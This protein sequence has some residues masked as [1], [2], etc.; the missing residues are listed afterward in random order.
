MRAFLRRCDGMG[1]PVLVVPGIGFFKVFNGNED[2]TA[3]P[4]ALDADSFM[5]SMALRLGKMALLRKDSGFS[6]MMAQVA[7]NI[8]SP[9]S[10][11]ETGDSGSDLFTKSAYSFASLT[12]E[13]KQAQLRLLP[14][15]PLCEKIGEENVFFFPYVFSADPLKNG[16]KLAA[17]IENICKE[18]NCEKVSLLALGCGSTVVT[19]YLANENAKNRISSLV[20]CFAPLDGSLLASDLL[21]DS[22]DYRKSA[23]FLCTVMKQEDAGMF[24]ELDNMIPGLLETVFEKVF[25]EVRNL[26]VNLPA[27]WALC[28]SDDY[29]DLAE[30]LLADKPLLKAKTDVF[31]TLRCNLPRTLQALCDC[32]VQLHILAGSALP[33]I[34]LSQSTDVV[35]DTLINTSSSALNPSVV[36][37][38][39][40]TAYEIDKQAAYFCAQTYYFPG[41][42]HMKALKNED[43]QTMLVDILSNGN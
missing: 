12:D 20:F 28:P 36:E 40:P 3:W 6:D 25:T 7:G 30:E 10:A 18:R 14:F 43:V 11:D 31:Q 8:L 9:F 23:S 17:C 41:V 13:E 27:A 5:K 42:A 1:N 24:I 29:E 15:L 35:S 38:A 39:D 34:P 32:G 26:F 22:F 4:P 19:A 2:T 21:L 16:K 33:F 37:T